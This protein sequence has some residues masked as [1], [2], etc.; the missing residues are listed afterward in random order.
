MKL[1]A[2]HW[3]CS[4]VSDEDALPQRHSRALQRDGG[5][6]PAV[7]IE[8][9]VDR[10]SP[11][12]DPGIVDL[13]IQQSS[14]DNES[15]PG[16]DAAVI[17]GQ[18]FSGGAESEKH[19]GRN[20][21]DKHEIPEAAAVDTMEHRFCDFQ[22]WMAQ[23]WWTTRYSVEPLASFF[24][25]KDTTYKIQVKSPDPEAEDMQ[26]FLQVDDVLQISCARR[27]TCI[28]LHSTAVKKEVESAELRGYGYYMLVVQELDQEA[29]TYQRIGIAVCIAEQDRLPRVLGTHTA[30]T[31]AFNLI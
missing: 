2:H 27:Y 30:P 17:Q 28:V 11:H 23:S 18:A 16:C 4:V 20:S 13:S 5:E 8:S 12:Q 6:A 15:Q 22:K 26:G 7:H 3:A 19:T 9:Q 24:F 29:G 10:Q 14:K 21:R 1:L 25:N 31:T